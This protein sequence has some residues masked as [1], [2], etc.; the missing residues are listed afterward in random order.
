MKFC[1]DYAHLNLHLWYIITRKT[2]Y[3]LYS[4]CYTP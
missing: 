2:P 4:F 3:T 1:E